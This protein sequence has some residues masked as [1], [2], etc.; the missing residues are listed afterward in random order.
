[1]ADPLAD[2]IHQECRDLAVAR[3]HMSLWTVS[4]VEDYS[5]AIHSTGR[6]AERRLG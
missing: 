2:R 4:G 1:M 5:C 3:R 6:I